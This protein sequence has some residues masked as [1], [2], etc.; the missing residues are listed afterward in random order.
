MVILVRK[1]S[2]SMDAVPIPHLKKKMQKLKYFHISCL[3]SIQLLAIQIV[4]L[5]SK[6]IRKELLE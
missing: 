2:F 3:K 6:K 5:V 4:P 1:M